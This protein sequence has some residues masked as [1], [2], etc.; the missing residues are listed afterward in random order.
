MSAAHGGAP[1]GWE[2]G[3]PEFKRI[4]QPWALPEDEKPAAYDALFNCDWARLI[5]NATGSRQMMEYDDQFRKLMTDLRHDNLALDRSA[6]F[7]E[8]C[9]IHVAHI[10]AT[11][12]K[13]RMALPKPK[14]KPALPEPTTA[15]E[16]K[17]VAT[18][19]F[20][21]KEFAEAADMYARAI[22]MLDLGPLVAVTAS[23]TRGAP[24]VGG[25]MHGAGVCTEDLGGASCRGQVRLALVARG[26]SAHRDADEQIAP[27]LYANLAACR[28]KQQRWT[29]VVTA[30]D[31]ALR[32]RPAYE[33]A[34]M[35]R[36]SA[37]RM[38]KQ[39]DGAIEDAEKAK[40]CGDP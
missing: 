27:A 5:L 23:V 9:G 36:A 13:R 24:T 38:L 32:L 28:V 8:R 39:W 20:A 21:N 26:C 2:Q 29:E 18:R 30:C 19:L 34:M 33:K 16:A 15:S 40:V 17:A 12:L 6:L 1:E 31:A 3:T 22:T 7:G 35:R 10:L 11:D 4:H 25:V 37:K 14:P